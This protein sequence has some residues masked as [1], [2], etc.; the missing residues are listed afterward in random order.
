MMEGFKRYAKDA[1]TSIEEISK[2]HIANIPLG[3]L[4]QP[5]D[6]ANTALYFCSPLAD[7]VTGQSIAVDG[8]SSESVNY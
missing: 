1:D 5:E 3:R 2:Q 4:I 8:G 6:I 7:I